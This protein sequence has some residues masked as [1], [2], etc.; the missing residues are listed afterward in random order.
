MSQLVT[1]LLER[2]QI[3]PFAGNIFNVTLFG[4]D[5]STSKDDIQFEGSHLRCSGVTIGSPELKTKERHPLT[6]Q[7]LID[8]V[9][10]VDTVTITWLEDKYLDVWNY[11]RTWMSYF[12]DR[13]KDQFISGAYGKKRSATIVLQE[14]KDMRSVDQVSVGNA[15]GIQGQAGTIQ[16]ILELRGLMPTKLPDLGFSWGK[17]D[18]QSIE[19]P[20]TYKIDS[21]SYKIVDPQR[22]EIAL[23]RILRGRR[24]ESGEGS[25]S[26]TTGVEV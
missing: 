25:L 11:H 13:E 20:L 4:R 12:Y 6:K 14:L 23:G 22:T 1:E 3:S 19:I 26:S 2:G 15:E 5:Q 24:S 17:D 16:H 18:Q 21:I 10:F 9:S 8:G 7:Q